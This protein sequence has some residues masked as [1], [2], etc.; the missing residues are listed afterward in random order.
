MS[1]SKTILKIVVLLGIMFVLVGTISPESSAAW[2]DFSETVS[3]FPSFKN[4][5]CETISS[6]ILPIEDF[7]Y[8]GDTGVC[9][10][11]ETPPP[12]GCTFADG[13][14]CLQTDDSD[15]SYIPLDA[16]VG[17]QN[18]AF[19]V[20]MTEFYI[21]AI[22]IFDVTISVW[23]K[24]ENGSA[25]PFKLSAAV[26]GAAFSMYAVCPSED[27]RQL[28]K[29]AGFE[30]NSDAFQ[31][32]VTFFV[33]RDGAHDADARFT[34]I[35]VEIWYIPS[36]QCTGN[37][38]ENMGCQLGRFFDAFV[39]VIRFVVNGAVYLGEIIWWVGVMTVSFFAMLAYFLSIPD[40]PPLVQGI[41]ATIFI[42]L[43][44]FLSFVVFG[45][46]RGSGP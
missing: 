29:S 37:W 7:C 36:T 43:L 6:T 34:A 44:A 24:T 12:V 45:A 27:Y 5:F 38:F 8:T 30:I 46:V 11:Y 18:P 23:C 39:K 31:N 20:N 13:H 21:S 22:Q 41:I 25:F 17:S 28:S 9:N 19:G 10:E 2:D 42:G 33:S 26:Q 32:N 3:T 15:N 4:P 16:N 35:L 40:A 1:D 14:L